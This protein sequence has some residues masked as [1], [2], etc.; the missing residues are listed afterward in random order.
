MA[1]RQSFL[2]CFVQIAQETRFPCVPDIRADCT[3]ICGCQNQQKTQAFHRLHDS[4][5]IGDRLGIVD[6]PPERG[7]AE[8]QVIPHQPFDGL[9]LFLRQTKPGAK[10]ERH[11]G[12]QL[13]MIT[14]PAF[15]DIVQQHR[16]IE[17]APR[18]DVVHHLRRNRHFFQISTILD[19]MQNAD[20]ENGMLVN[21][22]D[23]IHVMLHLGDH[24]TE[25]RHKA[26]ENAG[27]AEAA[28][29]RFRIFFRCQHL[30]KQPVRFRIVTDRIYDMQIARDC[31]Q[32]VWVDIQ[33]FRLGGVKKLKNLDR[34]VA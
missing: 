9:G 5:K 24:T 7:I 32:R 28:K 11:I 27:L 18:F 8:Q 19:P 1:A 21:G 3:D 34:I 17:R 25:I 10:V 15:G 16:H 22:I 26:P 30:D 23:M 4:A 29:S 33:P 14:T 13:G 12:A 2:G 20:C 6:I 31:A